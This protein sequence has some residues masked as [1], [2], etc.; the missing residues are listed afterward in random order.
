VSLLQAAPG[1]RMAGGRVLAGP[2]MKKAPKW[3]SLEAFA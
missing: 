3:L 1:C 2:P